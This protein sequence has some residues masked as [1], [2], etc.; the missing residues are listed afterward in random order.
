MFTFMNILTQRNSA[1]DSLLASSKN[2]FL[3]HKYL[4]GVQY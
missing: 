3:G 4:Q 2:T 1:V